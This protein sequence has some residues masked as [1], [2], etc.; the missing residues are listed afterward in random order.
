MKKTIDELAVFGGPKAFV[1]KLH[2]GSPNIGDRSRLLQRINDLLDRRW[3]TNNGP[4]VQELEQRIADMHEVRHCIA[5]CNATVGL[6]LAI[7]ALGMSGEV[8]IPSMTFVATAHA[9]QW[10]EIKPVFCDID[11]KTYNIDPCRIEELITPRTSGII[12]VHL[13]GRPCDVGALEGIARRYHLK[14]LYD[15]AHAI[16]CSIKGRM[17]GGFGNAEVF[18]FHA[19]KVFNS[20]EGGAITTNDD[21]LALK[22]QLM[23]NF[24]FAGYDNVV[25]IGINGKMNEMSAAM[26]LTSLDCFDEFVEVNRRN[27]K[28]YQYE[29]EGM[30]G[31]SLISYNERERFNYQYIVLDIDETVMQ[32]S[33]DQLVAILWMEN[34]LARRY[35]Y[36]GCHLMEPYRTLY[37]GSGATLPET[38]KLSR[39]ILSLPNGTSINPREISQICQL[40]R[41]VA[42]N[43]QQIK[44]RFIEL[45]LP[46]EYS[47]A[48]NH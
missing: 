1:E 24:G 10:Q 17:I 41:F 29:L 12:G 45:E 3:L 36:P 11:P 25:Y 34:V 27:Y 6:E 44:E 14:L 38:E 37:P 43:S 33:R 7:K 13:F 20:L 5:V 35:F 23:R 31:V 30:P 21:Q 42:F 28:Q 22:L 48:E 47:L 18:S 19:T 9:L 15:S 40:I 32:L 4:F 39:R 46:R 2:V 8:I 16:G 26:G